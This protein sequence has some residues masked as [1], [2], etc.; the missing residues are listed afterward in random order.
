MAYALSM[1][2]DLPIYVWYLISAVVVIPLVT[3]GV[4]LISRI[5]M[6]TQPIWLFLMVLPFIFIFAKEPDAIRGLMNFAGSSGYDSTFNIYM[7]GTA[8]AIGMALIPQ[9]G[10]QVD[11]LRF[12]P[13][14]TQKPFSL[15]FRSHLRR[16]GL[17]FYR[18]DQNVCRGFIGLPGV[19]RGQVG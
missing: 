11:F 7:F 13:E 8:I 19:E 5:Q 17:D 15:A 3:H 6:I 12:M 14:K 9:V 2:F 10:E 18:H 1:Y 4:T 16:S